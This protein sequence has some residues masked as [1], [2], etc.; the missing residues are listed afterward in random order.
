MSEKKKDKGL[1]KIMTFTW[2]TLTKTKDLFL[3]LE[4]RIMHD[5]EAK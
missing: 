5:A 1:G 3:A 4:K 2:Q